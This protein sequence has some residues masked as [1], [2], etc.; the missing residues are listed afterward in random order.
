MENKPIPDRS[1]AEILRFSKEID[2][3]GKIARFYGFQPIT[4][5]S[6]SKDETEKELLLK[7]YLEDKMMS[8]SQPVMFYL[9]RPIPG[10]KEARHKRKNALKLESSLVSIGSYKSV[11]ECLSIQTALSI[12]RSLGH[13]NLE[14]SINTI[15]DKDS[16]GEFQKKMSVFVRKNFNSFPADLRQASKKDLFAILK[17]DKE[18]W[19]SFREDSPKSIDFLS[20]PSRAHFKEVLEC[21]EIMDV[22]YDIDH[23]LVGDMN[24]GSETIFSIKEDG[25]ELAHGFRFNRLAKKIGWK[26]DIPATTLDISVKLK[27]PLKKVKAKSVSPQFYLVQFGPEAKLKSFLVLDELYK[28]G[29]S[30]VHSIAKDKLGS[31]IGV[32]ETSEAPYI[33]LLG[34]K[35]ALENSVVLRNTQTRAQHTVL[36][37]DLAE[38]VKELV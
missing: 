27:R 16:M 38:K 1:A 26:R 36:I 14:V 4:P 5:P 3:A 8:L 30:V 20:E 19:K 18:E 12:L 33:L 13:K 25:E 37:K 31:Q 11:C 15:G 22:C 6:A 24:I 23:C 32:A 34:Q 10:T 35:E 2:E 9:E 17:E 29:V 7:M 21:L 28:A